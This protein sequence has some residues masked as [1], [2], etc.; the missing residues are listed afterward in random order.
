MPNGCKT[1]TMK[2][3]KQSKVENEIYV[4]NKEKYIYKNL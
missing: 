2:F 4:K 3:F 1:T